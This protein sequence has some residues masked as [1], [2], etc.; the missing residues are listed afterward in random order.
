MDDIEW[1]SLHRILSDTT[2]R[3]I[4]ELLSEKQ[5]LSY[6]DV[7]TLLQI[8]NTGRLNYHLKALGNLISK[9]ADGKYSL[10]DRGRVA[11]SL[12][13]TFPE[14]V[15]AEKRLSPLKITAAVV[16]ILIG[17]LLVASTSTALV[18]LSSPAYVSSRESGS[19][20]AQIIPQNT[21]ISLTSWNATGTPLSI[22]W[23]ASGPVH[24]YVLN[25]T[26]DDA[27]L[28]QHPS[29]GQPPPTFTGAPASSV[30]QYYGESGN[31]TL[32]LPG[33]PYYF[34][35]SSSGQ[36]V[37]NTFGW[38][39]AQQPQQAGTIPIQPIFYLWLFVFIAFGVLLIVLAVSILTRR[40]WR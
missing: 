25:L 39:Q 7:M 36:A 31:Q 18:A 34:F 21:T 24:I 4:L 29:D 27:L 22:S 14:R 37:L 23:G 28:L 19:L 9:D 3:S 16:L 11:V 8:T 32:S 33:G 15:P 1:S 12:L 35:A 20:S 40:V 30:D 10:T 6:T 17:V 38:A 2:R 13:R 26:E 5:A